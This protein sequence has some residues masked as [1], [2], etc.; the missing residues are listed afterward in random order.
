MFIFV[1][2]ETH[3]AHFSVIIYGGVF[4]FSVCKSEKREGEKRG[5][6]MREGQVNKKN[7]INLFMRF[8]WGKRKNP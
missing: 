5:K 2:V 3:I 4:Y 8:S 7:Y 6:R 1:C